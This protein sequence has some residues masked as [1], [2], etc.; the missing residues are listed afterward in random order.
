[1]TLIEQL[2]AKRSALYE[3]WLDRI[4]SSYPPDTATFLRRERNQFA[5]PVGQTFAEQ[6][7]VLIDL[8]LDDA[9][10]EAMRP[11]LE[12]IAKIRA[13]QDFTPGRAM[14]F[15][16][17]LKQAIRELVKNTLTDAAG[18]SE[19]LALEARVDLM[20]L[21][22]FDA[23]AMCRERIYEIRI[24]EIKRQVA[25]VL[26]RTKFFSMSD[27]TELDAHAGPAAQASSDEGPI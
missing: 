27:E 7:R 18:Y 12:T 3:R 1:M 13:V 15:V 11:P 9:G 25:S 26:K 6:V 2:S 16:F 14:A 4:I 8:L 20:A 22:A 21:V 19:L 5:N 24:S 10:A 23:L 17:E